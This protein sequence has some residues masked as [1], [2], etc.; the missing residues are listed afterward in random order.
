MATKDDCL[1]LKNKQKVFVIAGDQFSNLNLNQNHKFFD[2]SLCSKSV[3]TDNKKGQDYAKKDSNLWSKSK[4]KR[5]TS[6]FL[7]LNSDSGEKEEFKEAKSVHSSTLSLHIAAY[8]NTVEASLDS[9]SCKNQDL[10][11]KSENRI[12]I[13]KWKTPK[14]FFS[15]LPSTF[16]NPFEFPRQ[17]ENEGTKAPEVAQFK[18]S[19]KLLN[20]N[21]LNASTMAVNS[22]AKTGAAKK[23]YDGVEAGSQA[24]NRYLKEK[25]IETKIKLAANDQ[26]E[27]RRNVQTNIQYSHKQM[28][29]GTSNRIIQKAAS[30]P[31]I[32]SPDG[33]DDDDDEMNDAFLEDSHACIIN[34][35]GAE[36]AV[37][38]EETFCFVTEG[39]KSLQYQTSLGATNN[40]AREQFLPGPT[41]DGTNTTR[42]NFD[43]L[44]RGMNNL[45]TNGNFLDE[46]LEN[47]MKNPYM[48]DS[49]RNDKNVYLAFDSAKQRRRLEMLPSTQQNQSSHAPTLHT[50]NQQMP[51]RGNINA[52]YQ[53]IFDQQFQGY[54]PGG[55]QLQQ[56]QFGLNYNQ[57]QMSHHFY[58]TQQRQSSPSFNF[59]N[60]MAQNQTANQLLSNL[61]TSVPQ[62]HPGYGLPVNAAPHLLPGHQLYFCNNQAPPF[63]GNA[64]NVQRFSMSAVPP[65][66]V[67]GS[68]TLPRRKSSSNLA[69]NFLNTEKSQQQA[70]SAD[71]VNR[72]DGG[73]GPLQE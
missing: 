16:Q 4:N 36:A 6:S 68:I 19:Q 45:N 72:Q 40:T 7:N 55:Q 42:A 25:T 60:G 57:Q 37:Q 29:G 18:A 12:S 59:Q 15:G 24:K 61:Q 69:P 23:E 56:N 73:G 51:I 35:S 9:D 13:N 67:V 2:K 34:D 32:T 28:H 38:A 10:D 47:L 53:Q 27:H 43:T 65:P 52:Q 70:T 71:Q 63:N 22:A 62:P 48:K 30:E 3:T 66:D 5:L 64:S 26:R 8:E 58:Q 44:N 46:S 33:E 39:A 14:Y 17:Q 20:S 50:L 21:Q 1:S 41:N 31:L 49:I 11:Y 54:H